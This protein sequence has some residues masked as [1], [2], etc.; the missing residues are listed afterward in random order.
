M[1]TPKFKR[2]NEGLHRY[3]ENGREFTLTRSRDHLR[4]KKAWDLNRGEGW[5]NKGCNSIC[6][7]SIT[8]GNDALRFITAMDKYMEKLGAVQCDRYDWV[9]QTPVGKLYIGPRADSVMCRFDDG[10]AARTMPEL[11]LSQH[12]SKWNFHWAEGTDVVSMINIFTTSLERVLLP[13][14]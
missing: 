10:D 12:N 8:K 13:S 2:V 6:I 1:T 3:V 11:N 14:K 7:S 9:L 5:A 4:Q